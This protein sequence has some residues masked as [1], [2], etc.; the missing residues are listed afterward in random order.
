MALKIME[1]NNGDK[2]LE[3]NQVIKTVLNYFL[4]S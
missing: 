1:S 2:S 3:P 4:K